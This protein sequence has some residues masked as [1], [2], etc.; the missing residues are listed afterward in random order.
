MIYL[1]TALYDEAYPFLQYYKMKKEINSLPFEMYR[2]EEQQICLTITGTGEITAAT[3]VAA[4]C[5]MG[6]VK[7]GDIFVQCGI[8]AGAEQ[9]KGVA[10]LCSKITEE[11]TQKT[12]YPDILYRHPFPEAAVVTG[13]NVRRKASVSEEH[14]CQKADMPQNTDTANP[15]KLC[16]TELYNIEL[17]DMEAAAGDERGE[18]AG[19]GN[20]QFFQTDK[21][22]LR[23]FGSAGDFHF[24]GSSR[25]PAFFRIASPRP[26]SSVNRLFP[27][28]VRPIGGGCPAVPGFFPSA[29]PGFASA[30][31]A[32][33][34]SRAAPGRPG[35]GS[36]PGGGGVMSSVLMLIRSCTGHGKIL[37]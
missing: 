21:A 28:S 24:T 8:C 34:F 18:R 7:A 36:P 37:G 23:R 29:A 12:F 33:V 11:A 13:M 25:F 32:R 17:Y 31:P 1:F 3:V 15:V 26:V 5:A 20:I 22:E 4:V 10:Y 19:S 16:D 30:F 27:P 2:C 6:H 14:V 9:K 35:T